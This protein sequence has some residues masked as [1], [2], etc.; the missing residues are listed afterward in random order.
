V[1]RIKKLEKR[2]RPNNN[3]N[4]NNNGTSL[5]KSC[6]LLRAKEASGKFVQSFFWIVGDCKFERVELKRKYFMCNEEG[7]RDYIIFKNS[8]TALK[9]NLL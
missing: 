6:I 5:V 2:P 4:N 3:N 8:E 9:L 7:D 1:Y